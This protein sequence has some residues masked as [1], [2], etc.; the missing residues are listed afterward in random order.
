MFE[1]PITDSN[2]LMYAIKH[3]ENPECCNMEE[4]N[5]DINRIK[6]IKRLLRRYNKTKELRERL[7]L[8]HIIILGNL[9]TPKVASRILIF[10]L[11]KELHVYLKTFLVFLEFIPED[12]IMDEIPLDNKIITVLR[13]L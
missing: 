13:A 9:F 5:E 3:Y 11:E 6:Y 4:F 2:F 10:K 12:G 7:I 8:N 1:E